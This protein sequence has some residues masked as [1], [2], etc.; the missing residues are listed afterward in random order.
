M[1]DGYKA[2]TGTN[3][4]VAVGDS[5]TGTIE[6]VDDRDWFAVTLEEGET[7]RFQMK[8][9]GTGDGTLQHPRLYGIHD[10]D[11]DLVKDVPKYVLWVAH[12]AN[13]VDSMTFTPAEDGTYYVAAGS[14]PFA[15][16][17]VDYH[18]G[19]GTYTLDVDAM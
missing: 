14:R 7:Y 9:S 4:T 5:A 2:N 17:E 11:G 15:W 12:L 8:G 19:V 1:S 13:Y 18:H 16:N 3:G 6:Y 10:A